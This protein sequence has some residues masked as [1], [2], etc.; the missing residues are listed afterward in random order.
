MDRDGTTGQRAAKARF[1]D[2]PHSVADRDRVVLGHNT[3]HL[4]CEHPVQIRPAGAPKGTRFLFRGD[5]EL[6]VEDVDVVLAQEAICLLQSADPRQ[7]KL[8]GQPYAS[9]PLSKADRSC[10]N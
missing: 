9:A 7:S 1:L 10:V 3:F 5:C 6:A 4:Y 2:L 8:L